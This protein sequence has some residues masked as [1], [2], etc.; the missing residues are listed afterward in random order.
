MSAR[1]KTFLSADALLHLWHVWM[2]TKSN[3]LWGRGN[4]H[5]G[6]AMVDG[7]SPLWHHLGCSV[8]AT[9]SSKKVTFLEICPK[10]CILNIL[11][12]IFFAYLARWLKLELH[13]LAVWGLIFP[14]GAFRPS[15]ARSP[16]RQAA[17]VTEG[18]E[19]RC[20]HC[21]GGISTPRPVLPGSDVGN[22]QAAAVYTD[23]S[24]YLF[25]YPSASHY[26][27]PR[28]RPQGNLKPPLLKAPISPPCHPLLPTLAA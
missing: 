15:A 7:N 24:H 9:R 22:R 4:K 1:K 16:L 10:W 3:R 21:T 6:E 13:I 11:F 26:L 8:E 23:S 20:L 2:G 28:C 25:Y 12:F 18:G 14:C 27:P 17:P 19:W 5:V